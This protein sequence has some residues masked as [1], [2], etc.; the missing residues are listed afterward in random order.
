MAP[1]PLVVG[2]GMDATIFV[3]FELPVCTRIERDGPNNNRIK[4]GGH[5]TS[6][7]QKHG[8][9]RRPE[10]YSADTTSSSS[11]ELEERRNGDLDLIQ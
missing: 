11:N 3:V 7:Q 10:V 5:T 8:T 4:G 1:D 6:Q 2:D 9:L